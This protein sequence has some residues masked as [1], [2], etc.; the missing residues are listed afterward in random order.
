[1]TAV[2]ERIYLT[3]N[4][5]F[6]AEASGLPFFTHEFTGEAYGE[7]KDPIGEAGMVYVL[8]NNYFEW[9]ESS[10]YLGF[11]NG[12]YLEYIGAAWADVQAGELFR[13]GTLDYFN[14]STYS[15]TQ[16]TDVTLDLTIALSMPDT[17]QSFDIDIELEN[18]TNSTNNT[19]DENADFVRISSLDTD[20]STTIDGIQ[21][22]LNLAFGYAGEQGF[23][24]VDEF[25]VHE[26]ATTTADLWGY[27][28]TD[29]F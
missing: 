13:L 26:G 16:A 25:F 22:Q 7:F 14:G 9:G 24:T 27:F 28:T 20:F 8:D 4:L 6:G 10:G 1:M 2:Y 5:A 23:T 18:T 3:P 15:G 21:Y 17:D 29:D 11:D 19:E 12:S